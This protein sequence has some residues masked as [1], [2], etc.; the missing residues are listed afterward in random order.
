MPPSRTH[1]VLLATLTVIALVAAACGSSSG[2]PAA[3]AAAP[4]TAAT[5]APSTS[6]GGGGGNAVTIQNFAFGPATV[7]V[8]VGT[9]VTWTNKDSADH[10]V[11]A[12]DGSFDSQAISSG[13]T[14]SQAFAKAGTFTYHCSIHT[15]MTATVTVK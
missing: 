9:T 15:T 2:S 10:T 5:S 1:A 12:D 7:E 13:K 4:S 6:S 11:T 3:T 14:F 8:P